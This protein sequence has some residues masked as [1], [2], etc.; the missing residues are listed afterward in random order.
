M[1]EW[2]NEF[3]L[4]HSRMMRRIFLL[5]WISAKNAGEPCG[6]LRGTRVYDAALNQRPELGSRWWTRTR[7]SGERNHR[8]FLSSNRGSYQAYRALSSIPS[9]SLP[10]DAASKGE[11]ATASQSSGPSI[12]EEV[13]AAIFEGHGLL[14]KTASE[15]AKLLAASGWPAEVV[16]KLKLTGDGAL[17][18]ELFTSALMNVWTESARVESLVRPLVHRCRP[19]TRLTSCGIKQVEM[20]EISVKQNKSRNFLGYWIVDPLYPTGAWKWITYH[21]FALM[22]D[23]VAGLLSHG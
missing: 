23:D 14:S 17:T 11:D 4:L 6:P 13:S 15:A 21:Q 1:G 9:S 20:M 8:S 3:D 7:V 19:T 5:P 16:G 10:S 2:S 22:Y 12:P 18:A